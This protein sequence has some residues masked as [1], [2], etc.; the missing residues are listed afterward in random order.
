MV[1]EYIWLLLKIYVDTEAQERDT[2]PNQ[3]R[4]R[5]NQ[6]EST[7]SN[8]QAPPTKKRTIR[9]IPLHLTL[10]SQDSPLHP[11]TRPQQLNWPPVSI[12]SH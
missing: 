1:Y 8:S 2:R 9:I 3:A 11:N 10:Q 7:Q 12:A 5:P 4:A 6:S